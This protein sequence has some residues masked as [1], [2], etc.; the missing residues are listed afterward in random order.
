MPGK[1]SG[2]IKSPRASRYALSPGYESPLGRR[3]ATSCELWKN[4]F[5]S[6]NRRW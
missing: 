3:F 2:D 5:N 4:G 6:M 1:M